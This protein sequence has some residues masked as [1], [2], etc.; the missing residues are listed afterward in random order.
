M[1]NISTNEIM[2]TLLHVSLWQN[3]VKW[4]KITI[5]KLSTREYNQILSN[6]N[7]YFPN[8]NNVVKVQVCLK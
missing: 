4:V 8:L 1:W 7:H 3:R 5:I 2:S 6:F